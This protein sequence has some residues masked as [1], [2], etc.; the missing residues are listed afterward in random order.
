[1]DGSFDHGLRIVTIAGDTITGQTRIPQAVAG[2]T[3]T[4]PRPFSRRTDS[5]LLKWPPNPSGER[6]WVH[7]HTQYPFPNVVTDDVEWSFFADTV[8]LLQGL[9]RTPLDQP[10]Q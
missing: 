1:M 4:T 6:H 3:D 7:F 5:L 9:G 2:P 10:L 8:V